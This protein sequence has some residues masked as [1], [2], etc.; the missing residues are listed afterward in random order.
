MRFD[1]MKW[2]EL[3]NKDFDVIVSKK[4]HAEFLSKLGYVIGP[5][6]FLIDKKTGKKVVAEDGREISILDFPDVVLAA[7]SH[8]FIRDIASFSQHLAKKGLL[9]IGAQKTP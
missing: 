4:D 7:G 3:K 5:S 8:V 2:G 9:K 1:T 6:G